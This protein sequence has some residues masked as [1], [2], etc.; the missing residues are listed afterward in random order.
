[1]DTFMKTSKG[2]ITL[3][4]ARVTDAPAF[5]DLR[6]EALHNHP[7]AF[8]SDYATNF[9]FP[10]TFWEQ[11]L[12]DLGQSGAV[13]FADHEGDL[14]GMCGIHRESSP[15][16]QHT[17]T[18]WGVYVKEDFRGHQITEGLI[19]RCTAWAMEKG[20][21]VVKLAVVTASTRA[22]KTYTRCGFSV[23]GVEPMAICIDGT[24][25]DEM[26]MALML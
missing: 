25:Y 4:P 10:S 9:A 8:S 5:R 26:L 14:V 7:E 21:K 23:Y 24:M 22:I 1:M 6:L 17:A 11:R 12:S 3:R 15:K 13:F 19:S 16:L 2:E 18:I 20:V